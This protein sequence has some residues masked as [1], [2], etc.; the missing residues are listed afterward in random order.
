MVDPAKRIDVDNNV[1]ESKSGKSYKY[2]Y[3]V[4][5]TGSRLAPEM[6]PGLAE[7]A[8]QFYELEAARKLGDAINAF[9]GERSSS[10]STFRISV[11]SLFSRSR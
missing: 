10:T 6:V 11:R 1:V 9:E 3:L 4:I 2:D 5:A 7:G 8:H